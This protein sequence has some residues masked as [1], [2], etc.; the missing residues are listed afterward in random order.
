[1]EQ[2]EKQQSITLLFI[3]AG[4]SSRFG[5]EPKMLS[6]LG[7]NEESLFEISLVQVTKNIN[8]TQLHLVLNKD[9][10]SDILYEVNNVIKKHN[11]NINITHN[12]QEIPVHRSKPWGTA[13]AIVSAKSHIHNPF[14]LVNSDDLYDSKTFELVQEECDYS[15][16]YII[17]FK[18]GTTLT[19]S[20]KANRAFISLDKRNGRVNEL[21]EKLN[22]EKANYTEKELNNQYVSV[23]L[24]L[25]QPDVLSIMETDL[26]VF[27]HANRDNDIIEAMLPDFLN[28][29]IKTGEINM[30]ILKSSGIWNGVTYKDDVERVRDILSNAD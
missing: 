5:G 6:K 11:L 15:K 3:A 7:H 4:K 26:N 30:E 2:I 22:I 19:S 27:K 29:H 1:M 20:N 16:N 14:L 25:L 13:D 28:F 24:F 10:Q 9:N 23:N 18:L 12:I 21:Q 8:I 17:G